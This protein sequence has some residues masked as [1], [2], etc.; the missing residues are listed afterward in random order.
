MLENYGEVLKPE[1]V[2][3][4]LLIGRNTLY[5]LLRSKALVGYRDGRNWKITKEAVINYLNS[6]SRGV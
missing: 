3:E 4:I 1:D 2:C 6:K 5:K